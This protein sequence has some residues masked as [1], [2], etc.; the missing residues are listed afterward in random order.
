MKGTQEQMITPSPVVQV[1]QA[2]APAPEEQ[3]HGFNSSRFLQFKAMC[4]L[5]STKVVGHIFFFLRK[6]KERKEAAVL[7]E[8]IITQNVMIIVLGRK[9]GRK[10]A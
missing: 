7:L 8:V 10:M 3:P 6:K 9:G 1:Q 4:G 2:E 5:A